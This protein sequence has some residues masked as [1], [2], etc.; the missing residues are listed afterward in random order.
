VTG[1]RAWLG[2][3]IAVALCALGLGLAA[4]PARAT[5][6]DE[7]ASWVSAPAQPPATPLGA[8][9]APYPVPIGYI[10]DIEF[11][12]PN[13]GLLITAGNA[14][15]PEGLYAYNGLD[16]H[17]LSTV[18]GGTDGRIAW[19]GPDEFWTIADQRPGQVLPSGGASALDNLSLCHFL[20]GQVVGSYAMPLDQPDSFQQMNAAVCGS[21]DDCWF[22]GDVDS[23]GAF[24]LHWDGTALTQYD[25]VQ[26]EEIASMTAYNGQVYESVQLQPDPPVPYGPGYVPVLHVIAP[27]DP[28]NPFHNLYPDNNDPS[29]GQF[30]PP[31][32]QYGSDGATGTVPPQALN[33]FDLSSDS[34][35]GAADPQLWAVAGA[36]PSYTF[37]DGGSAQAI[38][39]RYA[40]GTWTQVVGG[41]PSVVP[42]C[43]SGSPP[44]SGCWPNQD[45]TIRTGIT[46]VSQSVAAE[47]DE[48]A[49]WI[50][51]ASPTSNDSDAEV[52]RVAVNESPGGAVTSAAVTDDDILGLP[53]GVAPS[54][55]AT[56]IA[57]PA[58][59]DCWVATQQGWLFHL[60]NGTQLTQDTD[61]NFAGVITYRPP[62]GGT[63]SV[64]PPVELGQSLTP[65]TPVTT[66]TPPPT[67]KTTG[68]L[69]THDHTR[70]IDRTV[71]EFSF[72]LTAKARVQLIARRHGR[73]VGE[74]K[75]KVLGKGRHTLKLPL[76]PKRWPTSLAL[77]AVMVGTSASASAGGGNV[78]TS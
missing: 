61:P 67:K 40:D 42:Q 71:L 60:T 5:T 20:N 1:V 50:A 62:D 77:H 33:G 76:N 58:P 12:A 53:Q 51:V 52:L 28:T 59:A 48:D 16:W 69:V 66:V 45:T 29:C 7:G 18:C 22:G 74:T 3:L 15:V 35:A 44:P 17:Q 72:T 70:L 4:G 13:R 57:C 9:P 46:P 24:H 27:D 56:A 75:R 41:S 31:L 55:P 34:A 21:A 38:V 47:P 37:S 32:P 30:C 6:A 65:P 2:V 23:S 14:I 10:G 49:A 26:D 54:G 36:D 73:T 19:A 68:P 63:P 78:T 39:L 43:P 11:W 8:Q 25:G 64:I